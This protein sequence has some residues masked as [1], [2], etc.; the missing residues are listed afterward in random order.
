MATKLWARQPRNR[1]LN[2]G[3][4]ETHLYSR[5]NLEPTQHPMMSVQW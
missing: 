1:L 2:P 3:R 4:G 5:K